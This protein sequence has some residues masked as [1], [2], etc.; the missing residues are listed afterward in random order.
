M[1]NE[2][3]REA[4]RRASAKWDK[5]NR[6]HKTIMSYRNGGK[7]FILDYASLEDLE[8]YMEYISARKKEL[9]KDKE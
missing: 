9:L 1:E 2:K 5:A 4:Q 8:E 3:A 7:R 6:K